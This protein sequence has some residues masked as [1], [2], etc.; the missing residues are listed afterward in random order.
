[1]LSSLH[2]KNL[3]LIQEAE[4]EFGSGLNILTGETGAGKSI[5]IGSINLALGK[6]LSREMIREGADS[7]LVEL[8]F[9]T[10][11]PKVE[12]ALKEMEI[13]S[14]H[15]QVLIVRKITG[16]RSI[17]KINGET[18]TTAQV[19]RIASLL[20]DIHGQHEHQSLLYT[21]R[22]LE[23]LDAYGKEEIDPLRARVRE[24]FRQWK[25][26]RDSL[27]EY[28]LDED[29]RMREIS[30]LEFE[31][32]E[33]DDAQLRDGEDETLEQAYRK[34][35][36]ARNIVQALAAVRA[37][38]GDGEGQSAGEQI[39]RA[40]R[41]LSQ[42]AGMDESLQQM[43]SSLLTIDDLLNDFN[44]ELA[45]Y[46]EEFTFSEEE[47]YETEK[48]LDEINRLKAKYGDSIPAIRRY[49]E[50]K[51]EKLEKMLHFEEQKEKLQKEEEKARQ[52]L[53]EC[54]QELS[55]IRCKYAGCL[56]KSIEEGLKDLNF[57]HV[58]FQ[59]QFGRT[60]QYT[61]NGF[62]TIE[63]RISTNPGEPVKA[64]AKVV[65]GGELSRIMLAIKTILAD[66]DETESLIFDEIDT[67]ISG[68]TAQMVSEKMAQIG[69][70]HQVLCITHLPQIAAMAD[71]HFEIRKDVVDQDTVTRIHALD[72]E[73]SVRELAR[74]LGG[75]KITDSVL[76][77]AEEMKE[78]AQVQK[79]TRL[80]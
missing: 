73:S 2:V 55:G 60:A 63:F 67:G 52:T 22:Q 36:N 71:Q 29:A 50:E 69:R 4:V 20:L 40:V 1:M 47:F 56:S 48:R 66:R 80:K 57:L 26:L 53:E 44:R 9:E 25:E 21:D 45:G 18:C 61:E 54:S 37:M 64:L 30:F 51:Q 46:M 43:Q 19:R 24:A 13:E 33:I 15:G 31:I 59:I 35:S 62:D 79:N 49:Q 68:R 75:A 34:M 65:S 72:E 42:I 41:E 11:N 78:L 76:A 32:R 14:L 27:K 77:N 12:Q 3:A 10:E 74:M 17:S 23:I 6:K 38:T 58:I 70:R 5:L 16:S 39:G 7:A 28:E 8:V